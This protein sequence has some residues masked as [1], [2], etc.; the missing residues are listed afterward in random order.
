MHLHILVNSISK[1]ESSHLNQA[2]RSKCS[3]PSEDNVQ[4]LNS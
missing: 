3:I 4:S 1:G 2:L